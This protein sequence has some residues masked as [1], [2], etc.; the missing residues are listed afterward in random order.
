MAPHPSYAPSNTNTTL[1][2]HTP[3]NLLSSPHLPALFRLLNHCFNHA[4]NKDGFSRLPPVENARLGTLS[5]LG[6]EVGPDGFILI[7]LQPS[8]S[9][10]TTLQARDEAP[11]NGVSRSPED[12]DGFLSPNGSKI[13]ATA[14]AK[15]YKPTKPTLSTPDSNSLGN[16]Q[17]FKRPPSTSSESKEDGMPK[18]EILAMAVDPTLQGLGLASK[19]MEETIGEIKKRCRQSAQSTTIATTT[20]TATNPH[21]DPS[22]SPSPSKTQSTGTSTTSTTNTI[23]T[24]HPTPSPTPEPSNDDNDNDNEKEEEEKEEGKSKIRLMLSTMQDLN[25]TYYA[26]RGWTTTAVRRFPPGTSGSRDGFG[27]VEMGKVVSL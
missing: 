1:L 5:Q 6:E 17:F 11:A 16:T 22:S 8:S 7:L 25:E 4:H 20:A 18:W 23:H 27:V 2:L 26:K 13:L 24:N 12:Q 21:P 19:L 10:S 9:T 14:S 15:P 3:H